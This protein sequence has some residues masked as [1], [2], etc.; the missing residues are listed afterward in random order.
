L[1]LC[2]LCNRVPRPK[3]GNRLYCR[4]CTQQL[5]ETEREE[6][7]RRRSRST[8]LT[9]YWKII[10]WKAHYLGVTRTEE[11]PLPECPDYIEARV[12]T[13]YLGYD[14][15]RVP[16]AKLIDLDKWQPDFSADQVRH[17]KD[18]MRRLAPHF[19]PRVRRPKDELAACPA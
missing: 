1:A 19:Q 13:R 14:L 10:K 18:L 9:S 5:E 15:K 16:E 7:N 8:S 6:K 4:P 2:L 17:M 11:R 3:D 12:T